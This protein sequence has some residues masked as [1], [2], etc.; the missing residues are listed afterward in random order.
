MTP[1]IILPYYSQEEIARY[2]KIVRRIGQYPKPS[3]G[4]RFLLAASPKTE[5]DQLLHS[6]CAQIAPT[7]SVKCPTQIF[8]YPAGPT[9]MFWDAMDYVA[10]RWG[11]EPGFSLWL[12]S[13]MVPVNEHWLD[14]LMLEWCTEKNPLLLG[15][16]VPTVYK[17]RFL[18]RSKFMLSEHING[19]ACYA[20]NLANI[21][22]TDVRNGVFDMTVYPAALELGAVIKSRS[23]AFSTVQSARRD[24]LNPN[25]VLL[26]GFMQDKQKFVDRCLAPVSA[27]EK[28]AA[29][30]IPVF[31]QFDLLKR[32]LTVRFFRFGKQAMYENMILTKSK[33]DKQDE[34]RR[35]A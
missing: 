25:L 29:P 15:C 34:S 13:D 18:R 19:G 5:P 20:K 33:V 3:T 26:H 17:R 4:F 7:Y 6:V 28:L 27:R 22:S 16:Y 2:L 8:G 35:A 9:A 14:R 24:V 31:N 23:I 30:L 1:I 12:E 11:H 21:L 10:E 32:Q